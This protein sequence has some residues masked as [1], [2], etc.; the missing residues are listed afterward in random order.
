VIASALVATSLVVGVV[1]T[2][3]SR[4]LAWR[5]GVVAPPRP[6]V[7]AHVRPVACLGGLGIGAAIA[8]VAAAG[9]LVDVHVLPVA[10]RSAVAM[11]LG[12][13]GY[14]ALGTVDDIV[15]L[16]PAPKLVLQTAVALAVASVIHGRATGGAVAM[17]T[18]W[19]VAV[20]NAV[21]L[22][23]VC[24]GLAGSL[25][26][27]ALAAVAA[28]SPSAAPLAL[29]IAAA[30]VGFLAFNRAPASIFLGDGGS[31]LLGFA[32]AGLWLLAI[33]EAPSWHRMASALLGVGVFAFEVV[34]LVVVRT[35]RR[36]PFWRA[37][38]DHVSMRLQ[39]A[40]LSRGQTVVVA[41]VPATALAGLSQWLAH[42]PGR[43][44]AAATTLSLLALV[45]TG[46]ALARLAPPPLH[47]SRR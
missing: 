27:V 9:A 11:A 19:I 42:A 7:P 13:A 2:W 45:A 24:D 15:P 26:A 35:Q 46:L 18:L 5:T 22:V 40:G 32:I 12:L 33:H 37:S 34:F 3:L 39:A 36:L 29:V 14:L 8:V 31:H 20:V 16:A 25:A 17:S 41:L 47:G 28:V 4:H 38:P 30:T 44:A 21:N 23:D 1:A 6:M 43:L 10:D